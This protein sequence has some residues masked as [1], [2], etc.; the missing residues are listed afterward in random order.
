LMLLAKGSILG[1]A[2]GKVLAARDHVAAG[3]LTLGDERQK[4]PHASETQLGARND[5][6]RDPISF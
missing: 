2:A 5:H 4:R 1:Q 6:E 3:P